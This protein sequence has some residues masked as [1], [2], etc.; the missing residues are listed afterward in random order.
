MKKTKTIMQA[1]EEAVE[2]YQAAVSEAEASIAAAQ[3]RIATASEARD[4]AVLENDQAAFSLAKDQI[5][6]AED[7]IDLARRRLKL[8]EEAGPMSKTDADALIRSYKEKLAELDRKAA[9]EICAHLDAV[10]VIA[11]EAEAEAVKVA[12]E[13]KKICK[14]LGIEAPAGFQSGDIRGCFT[15]SKRFTRDSVSI[16]R[17]R[18]GSPLAALAA[19]AVK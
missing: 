16:E 3:A 14:L 5:R 8:L 18:V 2:K 17:F 11:D 7:E 4:R 10:N 19:S 6:D 9:A 13:A 1:V 12:G 15:K